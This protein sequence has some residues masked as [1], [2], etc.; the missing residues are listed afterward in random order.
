MNPRSIPAYFIK[1][2][3]LSLLVFLFPPLC[4][5]VNVRGGSYAENFVPAFFLF[6]ILTLPPNN[7]LHTAVFTALYAFRGS[8]FIASSAACPM[9]ARN[10]QHLP[11]QPLHFLL[12]CRVAHHQPFQV[13]AS[14]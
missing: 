13:L 14:A 9:F 11:D 5:G 6:K 3:V 1:S 10:H 2:F 4:P 12:H 8:D 7:C